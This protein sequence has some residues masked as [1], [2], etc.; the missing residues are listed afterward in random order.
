MSSST[1][2]VLVNVEVPASV[3]SRARDISPRIDVVTEQEFRQRPDWLDEADVLFTQRIAP[4]RL[5]T[6]K[7]LKWVQTFGAG[8][9]WLLTPDFRGRDELLVTNASGIHAQPITE[10]VFGLML[11]FAR[12]LHR[13]ARLQSARRWQSAELQSSV[14]SLSGATLGVVGLGAIGRKIAAAAAVFGMR[15]IAL[16][17]SPSNVSGVER[18]FGPGQLVPF[19]KEAEYIV[20]TLPLTAQTR[21]LF[22]PQAFAAMRSDAVFINVGRGGTVQ[23]DALLRALEGG[24]IAGAALDVTDPEPLP[25]VH[26]LWSLPNVVITPHYAG[27]HPGYVQ[28]ASAIFLENLAR[29]VAGHELTNLVDLHQGY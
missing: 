18:V 13:A 29:F 20:N 4:E 15:V 22:G 3:L 5:L 23:T 21:G 1:L 16:K 14:S 6:A 2:I 24:S 25:A 9:E 27:S 7:R 10:H 28:R 26:P 19:L 8:V 12:Q 11:T 17:R